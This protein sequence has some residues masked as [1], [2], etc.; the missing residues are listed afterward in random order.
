MPRFLALDWDY[1]RLHVVSATLRGSRV[2]IE[3]AVAWTEERSPNPADADALG[4]LLRERLKDAGIAAAPVLVCLGR[5]RVILKEI[6]YPSVPAHEE[7]AV[8]QFQVSKELSDALDEVVIDYTPTGASG[9]NGERH[10]LALVAR[11]ELLT[12]YETLCRAAGLKLAAL[13]PRPFGMLACWK[14]VAGTAAPASAPELAGAPVALLS[15]EESGAEFCIVQGNELQLARSLAA[16]TTLAAEV[17]RSLTVYASQYPQHTVR[18]VYVAGG[19][20]HAPFRARLGDLLGIPVHPMDPFGGVD[21]REIPSTERGGFVS[22]VGLLHAHAERAELPINFAQPKK[23]KPPTNVNKRRFA[24]AAAVAAVFLLGGVFY[25]YGRLAEKRQE[26]EN[27]SLRKMGVERQLAALSEDEKRIAQLDDWTQ[28]GIIWLDELYDLTARFPDTDS[29]RLT[30]LTGDQ[31]T[32][33]TPTKT[34]TPGGDSL[35]TGAQNKYVAK[36]TLNGTTTGDDQ[37]VN[38]L[39]KR[40]VEDGHYYVDP[41]QTSQNA[42]PDRARFRQQF[43]AHM[44]I[45]MQPAEKYVRHLPEDEGMKSDRSNNRRRG[46]NRQFGKGR[47]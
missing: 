39:L 34:A 33:I 10:A 14:H 9:T 35:N 28:S 3:R 31:L 20:E 5:D 47:P 6:S 46:G 44:Q 7:P 38:D 22:A 42:G 24:V 21:R 15:V 17:R 4:R 26:Y 45:E 43:I 13:T 25:C 36:L 32:H 12:T 8:V 30:S 40:F 29:I 18:A 19:E 11:R 1:Q 16:G 37:A 23:P 2:H 41:K 27:M